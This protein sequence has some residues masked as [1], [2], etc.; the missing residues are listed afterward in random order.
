VTICQTD[1]TC[2]AYFKS[3]HTYIHTYH[4]IS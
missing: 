1:C 3:L 2:T 4:I